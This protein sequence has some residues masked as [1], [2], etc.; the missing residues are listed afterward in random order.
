[1][2]VFGEEEVEDDADEDVARADHEPGP[3]VRDPLGPLAQR[4][5]DVVRVD[6]VGQRVPR[7]RAAEVAGSRLATAV[8]GR[9]GE[10]GRGREGGWGRGLN[11]VPPEINN[12]R[13]ATGREEGNG[14]VEV[15][16]AAELGGARSL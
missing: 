12:L 10:D 16:D 14:G 1:M 7:H 5:G 9:G 13:K 3:L 6:C 4:D 2:A 11:V 15:D 8:S